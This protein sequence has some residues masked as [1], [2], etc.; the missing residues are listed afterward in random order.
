MNALQADQGVGLAQPGSIPAEASPDRQRS[1][2]SGLLLLWGLAVVLALAGLGEVALRDWDEGIVA[3]VALDASGTD[4]PQRLLPTYW[5]DPY[6]NK[7]PGIHLTIAALIATWRRLG[8]AGP[9]AVPPEWVVRL[10]PALLS[11][12]VVPLVGMLQL[13]LRPHDRL[14]ALAS[15]SITL[16][17][18]P[19]ARHGRMAML[20]GTQLSA[21]VLLWWAVLTPAPGARRAGVLAGLAGS[22]LLLL[23]APVAIPMLLVALLLRALDRELSLRTWGRLLGGIA[24]GLIPGVAWH[25]WHLLNRGQ[26]ALL[27]WTGQGFARVTASLGGHDGGPIPPCARCWWADGPGCC[28]GP[29]PSPWPGVS[30]TARPGAGVWL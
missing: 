5:G 18:L 3:G 10:A 14:A 6:L 2:L 28:S 29:S 11:S 12:A 8:G 9:A 30:A 27:M 17:L 26:A 21:M 4:W 7:P 15:A 22:A 1:A 24:L 23:K 16:T 19:V 20:D 25:G 13:R